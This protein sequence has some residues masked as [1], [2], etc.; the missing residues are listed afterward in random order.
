V[1][2]QVI[3]AGFSRTGTL[4]TKSALERL[5]FAPCYH[6]AEAVFPRPGCNEGHLDAW[7]AYYTAGEP[8]DWHWLMQAYRAAVDVPACLHVRELLQAYPDARVV[9]TTRDPESWFRSW[10]ALWSVIA[11]FRDP[12]RI[13]RYHKLPPLLHAILE[14]HLGGRIDHDANI[15]FLQAHNDSVRRIVPADR[16]LE[17][18]VSQGWAPLCRF[19]GVAV[20][21]TPFP[22]L[23]EQAGMRA[24]FQAALWT[25]APLQL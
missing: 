7:F 10:E 15:R 13:V 3:G 5:G 9:L 4:S 22:H 6:M 24:L 25:H 20:P 8:M 23:N 18:E 12:V 21:D 14:R 11:E 19:L 2:L 1:S 17:F 16:L